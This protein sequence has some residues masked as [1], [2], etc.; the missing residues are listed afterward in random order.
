MLFGLFGNKNKNK[1]C[2]TIEQL[3]Q[4][5]RRQLKYV[6]KRDYE[7]GGEIRLGEAGAVNIVGDDFTV[8]C[9]GKTV[10]EAPLTEVKAGELMDL[11]G[12]TASY[13]DKN[14]ERIC[15]VAKY[16]DGTVSFNSKGK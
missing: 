9:F 15:I 1:G 3:K 12:F 6:T 2:M 14:G 8:V 4:L 7:K 16:S 5:D 10:F 13:T 11:S